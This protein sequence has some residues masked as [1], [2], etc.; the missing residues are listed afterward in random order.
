MSK[1]DLEQVGNAVMI[2]YVTFFN[3]PTTHH[4]RAYSTYSN[5]A[6]RYAILLYLQIYLGAI[7]LPC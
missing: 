3:S 5:F 4:V 6:I 2:I 1:L 7:I